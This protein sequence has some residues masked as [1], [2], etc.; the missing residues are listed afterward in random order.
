MNDPVVLFVSVSDLNSPDEVNLLQV[1]YK[2][3]LSQFK[4]P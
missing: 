2:L 3:S 1:K 4:K